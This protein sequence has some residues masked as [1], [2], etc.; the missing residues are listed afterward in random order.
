MCCVCSIRNTSNK[1]TRYGICPFI[2]DIVIRLSFELGVKY[3]II[4][5]L[6]YCLLLWNFVVYFFVRFATVLRL[7][8]TVWRAWK[9]HF[10]LFRMGGGGRIGVL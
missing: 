3:V 1:V 9:G 6:L 10:N 7:C 8:M 2:I 4:F 5:Y